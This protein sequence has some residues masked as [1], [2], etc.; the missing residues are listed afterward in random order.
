MHSIAAQGVVHVRD[1]SMH[2]TRLLPAF[3]RSMHSHIAPAQ[4]HV[5]DSCTHIALLCI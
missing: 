3:R 5:R 1:R 2:L 4:V